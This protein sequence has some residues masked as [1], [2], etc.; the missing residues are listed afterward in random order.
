MGYSKYEYID[1][2]KFY[3]IVINANKCN[4]DKSFINEFAECLLLPNRPITLH[5]I[6]DAVYYHL[7][8]TNC[9]FLIEK[10]DILLEKNKVA[11][12]FLVEMLKMYKQYSLDSEYECIVEF[13]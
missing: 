1:D 4:G 13:N 7:L 6:N 11:Y 8:E 5:V 9:K 3:T 2:K 10:S 12:T